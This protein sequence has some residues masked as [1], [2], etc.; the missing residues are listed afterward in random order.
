[1]SFRVNFLKALISIVLVLAMGAAGTVC[2]QSAP[3]P[4]PCKDDARF[5]EFDFW[6]GEWDVHGPQG[7]LAGSNTIT[8]EHGSCVLIEDYSTP[9]GFTGMSVNYLDHATGEWVQ[10]WS[11]NSGSRPP[12][13]DAG[14][15]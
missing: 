3:P 7:N 2:A 1:M 5:S 14:T 15:R 12:T 11:D 6:L 4:T 10:I 8:S 13:Q 9:S